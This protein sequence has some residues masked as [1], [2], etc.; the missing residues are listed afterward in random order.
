[1]LLGEGPLVVDVVLEVER[2][3][4]RLG[5]DRELLT[6]GQRSRRSCCGDGGARIGTLVRR[7]GLGR[8]GDDARC[9]GEGRSG[10]RDESLTG[11][12]LL[13]D[14]GRT[15][16]GKSTRDP[17]LQQ[18][19]VLVVVDVEVVEEV[20]VSALVGTDRVVLEVDDD[21]DD[22]G[23]VLHDLDGD[24]IGDAHLRSELGRSSPQTMPERV[25]REE[26][27]REHRQRGVESR[28]TRS[29]VEL[30]R[31]DDLVD[32]SHRSGLIVAT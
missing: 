20:D 19:L 17:G 1:M 15:D 25:A 16:L 27:R 30:Q 24:D 26:E 6:G 3:R 13:D 22:V 21:S 9:L 2:R 11:S 5:S 29:L 18:V 14:H 12:G 28:R 8:D 31:A 32:D 4:A 10:R 7:T 23:L